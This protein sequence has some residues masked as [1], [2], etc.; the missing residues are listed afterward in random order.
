MNIY[1]SDNLGK[2]DHGW[3]KTN[4]HYSFANYYNPKRMGFG[5]LRVFNDD[6][7]LP[8]TGFDT[9]PHKNME[10]ISYVI[11]GELSHKDSMGTGETLYPG[12]VQYMSAGTG[13]YHSEFNHGE[14]LLRFVQ[15]WILPDK[16]NHSPNYGSH[17]FKM[18]ERQDKW[19]HMV[20]G[21][22]EKG[23]IIINQDSNIFSALISKDK[24]IEFKVNKNRQ[25]YG[26]V[27]NGSVSIEN[28][29]LKLGDGFD[30]NSTINFQAN[31]N[32][33]VLLIEMKEK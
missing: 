16:D 4:F 14:N 32:S 15:I 11:E 12:E 1:R 30:A 28:Q 13:V 24:E 25:V 26:I 31:E 29:D 8:G 19:L 20:S 27:I 33:H 2:G 22:T 18:E 10:I 7:V 21:K 23:E 3:L 17:R 5:D 6:R 9:H